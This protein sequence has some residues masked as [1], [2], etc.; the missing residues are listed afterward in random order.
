M[1]IHDVEQ[2]SE[3]WERLRLGIPTSSEF[4][5]ILTPMGK[6]SKQA[7]DYMNRL[8]AEWLFGGP[9]E[10]AAVETPWMIRGNALEMEA[11]RSYE[12]ERE[13]QTD[14]VGFITTDGGMIGASPD[15]M[16]GANGL[17]E[18]KCPKP[19]THV[20]HMVEPRVDKDYW[21][22]VQGQLWIAEREWVD[23]Q[24]YCPSFPT[25]IMRVTRD[26]PYIQKLREALL[27]FLEKM[28]AARQTLQNRYPIQE[29]APV[30]D[31]M[32]ITAD[33]EQAIVNARF[34]RSE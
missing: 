12:F 2:G 9:L 15:R 31:P 26:E 5:K 29:R 1:K 27:A 23:I 4:H 16:V 34:P 13:V 30:E 3:A 25:V 28:L 33:D 18:I 19:H 24:S 10:E 21:P 7:D 6:D 32:Q 14:K 20:G 17:L 22:Q 11:V 8:L